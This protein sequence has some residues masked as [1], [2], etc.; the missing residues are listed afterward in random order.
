[1]PGADVLD[2]GPGNNVVIQDSS[3]ATEGIVTVLG[4]ALDN[5]FTI[6]RNAAGNI[7]SNGVIIPGATVAN[8]ALIRV[9][10]RGGNDVITFNEANGALPAAMLFGGAGNDTLTG[11]SGSDL[12]FGGV[13]NDTLLGKG[14]FDFL[15]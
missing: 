6:S 7:L 4:D 1:G 8:T 12:I 10:G 9:F 14:G 15:F 3:N 13:D 5:T 11:G 2:G